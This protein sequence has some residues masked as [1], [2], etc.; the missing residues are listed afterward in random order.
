MLHALLRDQLCGVANAKRRRDDSD[1]G[2]RG[3]VKRQRRADVSDVPAFRLLAQ[4]ARAPYTN[5]LRFPRVAPLKP[6]TVPAAAAS[7]LHPLAQRHVEQLPQAGTDVDAARKLAHDRLSRAV[8]VLNAI[9]SLPEFDR[10]YRVNIEIIR[11]VFLQAV[12]LLVGQQLYQQFA[13]EIHEEW[14][15]LAPVPDI[16]AAWTARQAGKSTALAIVM[17]V[18]LA[19][20][21]SGQTNFI[22]CYSK[23]QKQAQAL[24]L[25]VRS[26]YGRLLE[27]G[28]ARRV[29]AES[30][31]HIIVEDELGQLLKLT[32]HSSSINSNR[33]DNAKHVYVDEFCFVAPDVYYQLLVG[34][35]EVAGRKITY[36]TTPGEPD[37][38]LTRLFLIWSQQ[39]GDE[40]TTRR[41]VLHLGLVC[42]ECT[43]NNVPL[44]CRHRLEYAAPWKNMATAMRKIADAGADVNKV[45]CEVL[46]LPIMRR[47]TV[48]DVGEY[49]PFLNAGNEYEVDRPPPDGRVYLVV[50]TAS[51]TTKSSMAVLSFGM[52][53]DNTVLALLGAENCGT[54]ATEQTQWNELLTRHV[55]RLF[56]SPVFRNRTRAVQ[57]VPI[58][59]ITNNAGIT[60]GMYWTLVEHCHRHRYCDVV[61]VFKIESRSKYTQYSYGGV[62]TTRDV[63][64]QGA[65]ELKSMLQMRSLRWARPLATTGIHSFT[66]TTINAATAA[67]SYLLRGEPVACKDHATALTRLRTEIAEQMKRTVQDAKDAISGKGSGDQQDDVV[68][69]M[70][71]GCYFIRKARDIFAR[72]EL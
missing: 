71:F 13:R 23:S 70:I 43:E 56:N 69:A 41:R 5:A 48:F 55:D 42:A 68:I 46:G 7:T 27:L 52:Y 19:C 37:S 6:R 54:F 57:L 40:A 11:S 59:E 35:E 29:V 2:A 20:G 4:W 47:P 66:R 17:C 26:A 72:Y 12:P 25:Q 65:A 36:T 10:L 39:R 9:V 45:M 1:D 22:S 3:A 21:H 18:E 8:D 31:E 28:L 67:G 64:L 15:G 33:G 30:S 61:D 58:M 34:I 32:I 44:E 38:T 49:G 14:L 16:V 63:K 60:N 51:A 53:E 24:L 62:N 50:D